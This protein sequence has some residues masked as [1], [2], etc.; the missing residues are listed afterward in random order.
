MGK[1]LVQQA[2]G[3]GGPTYRAPSFNY[4]GAAKYPAPQVLVGKVVDLVHC[5]G[6]SAPLVSVMYENRETG[7]LI[8]PEGVKVGDM[9]KIGGEPTLGNALMLKDIPEGTLICNIESRPGDGGKFVRAS[10]VFAKLLSKTG[11]M[12]TVM[13]PSRKQR[14]FLASC[15]ATIGTVA[16]GGRVEKPFM[17]A[18][19]KYYKM[20]QRNKYWPKTSGTSQNAVDHPFG[21]KRSSRKGRATVAPRFAPPGRNVG[22]LHPRKTGRFKMKEK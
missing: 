5:A 1:S 8:A 22:K 14:L 12:V 17:R 13:L 7:L 16:G 21:G 4:L 15:R 2:R 6:H 10:G 3:R 20:K 9:I 18:G 19:T 11:D